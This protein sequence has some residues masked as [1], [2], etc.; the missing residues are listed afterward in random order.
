MLS[1]Q[2]KLYL[3]CG[4]YDLQLDNGAD[5]LRWNREYSDLLSSLRIPHY[6]QELTDGHQWANWRERMPG[7]ITYFFG[8]R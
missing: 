8:G 3:D 1:P 7:M 4:T 6:Y 2:F 5:L